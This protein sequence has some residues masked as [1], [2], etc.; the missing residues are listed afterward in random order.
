MELSWTGSLKTLKASKTSVV[1]I[2]NKFYV[3]R[4]VLDAGRV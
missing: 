1:K 4:E 2:I 3:V